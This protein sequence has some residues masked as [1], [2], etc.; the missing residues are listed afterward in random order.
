ME[1]AG[2]DAPIL[3]RT[4][5]SEQSIEHVLIDDLVA[6]LA[7]GDVMQGTPAHTPNLLDYQTR[8]VS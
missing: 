1:R 7:L 4:D 2:G 3:L 5:P 8:A 6:N